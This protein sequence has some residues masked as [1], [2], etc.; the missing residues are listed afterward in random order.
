MSKWTRLL[1]LVLCMV[2]LGGAADR[3][4]AVNQSHLD[5]HRSFLVTDQAILDGFSFERVLTTLTAGTQTTPVQLLQQWLDTQNA[6]PGLV[7]PDAPHCDDFLT[8]GSPSF[9]G[10]PRR[11]P[12]PEGQL[13]PQQPFASPLA[14]II[15]LG[16][17]NRFDLAPVDGSNCGQ[18]RIIFGQSRPPTE[19]FHIIFEG[20]LPNPH[21]AAGLSACRPIAQFWADLSSV[22]SMTERGARLEAFFFQGL[23]GFLPVV[24]A[25]NYNTP[26]GIR[27]SETSAS[28]SN[29]MY[30]FRSTRVCTDSGGCRIVMVP[31]IL[32]NM[33]Y[34]SLFDGNVDTPLARQFR[35]DFI[36]QIPTLAIR[37]VNEYFMQIPSQYVMAESNPSDTVEQFLLSKSFARGLAT[38][39]GVDFNSRIAAE[40]ARIGSPL[41]PAQLVQRA[42]TQTCSGCHLF[43]GDIG[44]GATF[45]APWILFQQ[46]DERLLFIGESGLRFI[47]SPAM[48]VFATHRMQVLRD[49]LANGTPPV[50][51][52]SV[53]TIGGGRS[54]Q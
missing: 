43:S 54:V 17:I 33:I 44:G 35:E 49:F 50:H 53:G 36:K 24:R 32:D 6:K 9:N 45:P 18:Y 7:A 48:V 29:R 31:D 2:V 52:D 47:E 46:V 37:D 51:S 5:M 23:P 26:G 41:T 21:P 3:R 12:V 40:L 1:L 14:R 20:V 38:P 15:P 16:V 39:A 28:V 22:D 8:D 30:Q 10:F 34:G 27:T 13:A 11:C 19:L 25:E 4:R 42:E